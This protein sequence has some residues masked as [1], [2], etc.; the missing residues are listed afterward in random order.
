MSPC[1]CQWSVKQVTIILG[2]NKPNI[3]HLT[4]LSVLHFLPLS[5]LS[6]G[7]LTPSLTKIFWSIL[8]NCTVIIQRNPHGGGFIQLAA[9]SDFRL[10]LQEGGWKKD[11]DCFEFRVQ[12]LLLSSKEASIGT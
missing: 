1:Q 4:V 12:T 3:I 9:L 5:L 8:C 11:R 7:N 2:P 6:L 10:C